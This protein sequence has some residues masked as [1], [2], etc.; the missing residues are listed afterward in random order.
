MN[1][2]RKNL[3]KKDT[4]KWIGEGEKEKHEKTNL[5]YQEEEEEYVKMSDKEM[6]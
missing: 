2:E 1:K 5:K 4:D 3:N 6:N